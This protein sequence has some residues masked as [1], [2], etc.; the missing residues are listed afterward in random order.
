MSQY[1]EDEDYGDDDFDDYEFEDFE[2]SE[3][4]DN[5]QDIAFNDIIQSENIAPDV[6]EGTNNDDNKQDHN[7]NDLG[8]TE[9]HNQEIIAKLKLDEPSDFASTDKS[10]TQDTVFEDQTV[11]TEHPV[12]DVGENTLVQSISTELRQMMLD[13]ELQRKENIRNASPTKGPESSKRGNKQKG[14]AAGAN[15]Q[16]PS[17]RKKKGNDRVKSPV[18]FTLL[19]GEEGLTDNSSSLIE[20]GTFT[21]N[22]SSIEASNVTSPSKAFTGPGSEAWKTQLDSYSSALV[23]SVENEKRRSKVSR[24]IQ[25]HVSHD[26][27]HHRSIVERQLRCALQQVNSYRKENSYLTKMIDAS[28]IHA[29]FNALKIQNDEQRNVI[30]KLTEEKRSLLLIQRNQE[31]SLLDTEKEKESLPEQEFINKKKMNLFQ[32]KVKTLRDNLYTYQVKA[33]EEAQKN[34]VLRDQVTKLKVKLKT[35]NIQNSVAEQLR[36]EKLGIVDSDP[37]VTSKFESLGVGEES[38]IEKQ[39]TIV[40][41][42][43][44]KEE[45][46]EELRSQRNRLKSIINHQRSSFRSQLVV[47]QSKLDVS[48]V[49]RKELEEELV[50]REKEMKGQILAVKELNKTCEE[51]NKSNME[52]LEASSLYSKKVRRTV[53]GGEHVTPSP[54]PP[55]Q[56]FSARPSPVMARP[57]EPLMANDNT[58]LTG[59]QFDEQGD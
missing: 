28:A 57:K 9:D 27:K 56:T 44:Q 22:M 6:G 23:K 4:D 21:N 55:S 12:K 33:R 17:R 3:G 46:I 31:K 39:E 45:S 13:E 15:K 35:A 43:N 37:T 49:K 52:L 29:E 59:Q 2:D 20:G 50:R 41:E 51:L 8:S 42:A 58:F 16:S 32:K 47:L 36:K 48:L 18:N 38:T 1:G 14:S 24:F 19:P 11:A 26:A 54:R 5:D 10:F 53:G 30:K 34:K 7:Q 25:S 40:E